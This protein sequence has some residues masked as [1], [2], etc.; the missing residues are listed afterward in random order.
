MLHYMGFLVAHGLQVDVSLFLHN[1]GTDFVFVK[2][3]STL[4]TVVFIRF[5]LLYRVLA[6]H[7]EIRVIALHVQL[8]CMVL[9][10]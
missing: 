5:L 2:H 8:A 9:V 3:A 4:E 7:I 6:T 1:H 10:A